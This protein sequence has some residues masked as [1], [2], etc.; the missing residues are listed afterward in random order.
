MNR[1]TQDAPE[2]SGAIDLPCAALPRHDHD[3]KV[4]SYARR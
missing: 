3:P 4:R 2:P 1:K